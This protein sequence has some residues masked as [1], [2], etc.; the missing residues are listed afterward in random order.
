MVTVPHD[1][2]GAT[3]RHSRRR[4]L[5]SHQRGEKHAASAKLPK[6]AEAAEA[7]ILPDLEPILIL[8]PMAVQGDRP[9]SAVQALNLSSY[10][11]IGVRSTEASFRVASALNRR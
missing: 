8:T 9:T 7:Q 2:V 5:A 10:L 4:S 6:E 3:R 1:V 11:R